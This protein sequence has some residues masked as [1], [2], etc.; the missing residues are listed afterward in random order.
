[1][2]IVV[3]ITEPCIQGSPFKYHAGSGRIASPSITFSSSFSLTICSICFTIELASFSWF[4]A[5]SRNAAHADTPTVA[6]ARMN[7]QR[8]C[9]IGSVEH[10]HIGRTVIGEPESEGGQTGIEVS[11][12]IA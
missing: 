5:K 8:F 9:I 3:A 11:C 12:N 1:M 2:K 6:K 10:T 4:V 7:G